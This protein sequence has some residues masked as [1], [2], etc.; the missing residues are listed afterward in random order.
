MFYDENGMLSCE[1]VDLRANKGCGV[2]V[3]WLTLCEAIARYR[4]VPYPGLAL[5]SHILYRQ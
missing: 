2:V 3:L 5:P 1:V 4:T